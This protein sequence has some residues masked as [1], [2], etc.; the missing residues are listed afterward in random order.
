MTNMLYIRVKDSLGEFHHHVA[1]SYDVD[2]DTGD[3]VIFCGSEE[4]TYNMNH[5]ICYSTSTSLPE[6]Q[7]ERA[8]SYGNHS[9]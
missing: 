3:L 4:I 2:N 9:V 7:E 6:I 8:V 5:V 1:E